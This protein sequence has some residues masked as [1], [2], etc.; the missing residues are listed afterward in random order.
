M[1]VYHYLSLWELSSFWEE[2]FL[3]IYCSRWR[4]AHFKQKWPIQLSC[5]NAC[6]SLKETIYVS[7]CN[8]LHVVFQGSHRLSLFQICLFSWIFEH[9]YLC[10]DNVLWYEHEHQKYCY[11]VRIV[12]VLARN[13]SCKTQIPWWRNAHSFPSRP[14]QLSSRNTCIAPKKTIHVASRSI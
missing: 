6:I 10:K 8:I 13:T 7:R 14:I 9:M 2:Y 5:R 12:L 11:T 1:R 3:Q 4:K